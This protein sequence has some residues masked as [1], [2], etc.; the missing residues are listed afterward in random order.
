MV[1]GKT[2]GRGK[3]LNAC[4]SQA[5][6]GQ[7][8]FR[9]ETAPKRNANEG[10]LSQGCLHEGVTILN[11]KIKILGPSVAARSRSQEAMPQFCVLS[12]SVP[13]E[14]LLRWSASVTH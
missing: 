1:L 9:V 5:L 12:S 11:R 2:E 3:K 6:A 13:T 7:S 4:Q 14:G 10:S 8:P